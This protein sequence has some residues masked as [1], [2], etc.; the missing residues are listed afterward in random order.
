MQRTGRSKYPRSCWRTTQC[1]SARWAILAMLVWCT[2]VLCTLQV[3]AADGV[4]PVR[5]RNAHLTVY[6][7]PAD[8]FIVQGELHLALVW[9]KIELCISPY[10][11][12][13]IRPIFS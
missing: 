10:K 6:V 8:P 4:A 7:P 3:G 11:S 9:Q 1:F 5:S 2:A 13:F 12:I